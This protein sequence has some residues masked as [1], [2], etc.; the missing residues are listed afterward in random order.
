MTSYFNLIAFI[1]FLGEWRTNIMNEAELFNFC[2][3]SIVLEENA[4]FFSFD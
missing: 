1:L 4:G 2:Q 3:I